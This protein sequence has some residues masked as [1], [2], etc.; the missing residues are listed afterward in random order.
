DPLAPAQEKLHRGGPPTLPGDPGQARE[1]ERVAHEHVEAVL[2]EAPIGL[3]GIHPAGDH[4]EKRRVAHPALHQERAEPPPAVESAEQPVASAQA[5][6]A[7]QEPPL[8]G[9][10]LELLAAQ[11][12]PARV[13]RG[14]RALD[15]ELGRPR[16]EG[17]WSCLEDV[18]GKEE[19][20]EVLWPP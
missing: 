16:Q 10:V 9:V 4:G 18:R 2:A 3:E 6:E 1:P 19:A 8:A 15:G 11:V 12:D 17:L 14:P 20:A 7:E 5:V 13:T